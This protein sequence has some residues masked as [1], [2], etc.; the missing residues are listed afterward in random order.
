LFDKIDNKD[1]SAVEKAKQK[2]TFKPLPGNK[3]Y[4]G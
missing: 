4:L 3:S 2:Y 1:N